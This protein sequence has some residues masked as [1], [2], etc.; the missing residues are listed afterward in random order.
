MVLLLLDGLATSFFVQGSVHIWHKIQVPVVILDSIFK[1]MTSGPKSA[2]RKADVEG[3]LA[4]YVFALSI[5][6]TGSTGFARR[7]TL[8]CGH[9]R[10]RKPC[11]CSG[12]CCHCPFISQETLQENTVLLLCR[13][14]WRQWPPTWC[15]ARQASPSHR[16][17]GT[18]HKSEASWRP[19]SHYF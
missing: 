2:D 7:L 11:P 5:Q 13:M 6:D 8:R 19:S 4:C 10:T 18:S 14:P 3:Q 17:G 16:P 9:D 15:Q 12:L 1:T